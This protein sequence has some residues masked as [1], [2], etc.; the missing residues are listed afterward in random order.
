MS[1][2]F[3]FTMLFFPSCHLQDPFLGCGLARTTYVIWLCGDFI[4]KCIILRESI[5]KI[6]LQSQHTFPYG[7][8]S[9]MDR[10]AITRK[11]L[12]GLWK[13]IH[14]AVSCYGCVCNL[15]KFL[16]YRSRE[17]KLP[18]ESWFFFKYIP[19]GL[20]QYVWTSHHYLTLWDCFSCLLIG[21]ADNVWGLKVAWKHCDSH[22][23]FII[24]QYFT[25][26]PISRWCLH[27]TI[28]HR[29]SV[30]YG[31]QDSCRLW[32][33]IMCQKPKGYHL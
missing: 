9:S 17:K 23:V 10:L 28:Q 16:V 33:S 19:S 32:Q 13:I 15:Y 5:L 1:F 14:L 26:Y 29:I 21:S 6:V 24:C 3:T 7:I 4:N 8:F 18:Q 20:L 11:L 22:F 25:L 31:S 27:S 30:Y 2:V 12:P